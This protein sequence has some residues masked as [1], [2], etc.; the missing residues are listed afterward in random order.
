MTK[1]FRPEL[2]GIPPELSFTLT[3]LA[4]YSTGKY[5]AFM[6][7]TKST[8]G[9][10]VSKNLFFY[11]KP[12]TNT[13][14]NP[15]SQTIE[16][17]LRY[18]VQSSVSASQVVYDIPV[19]TTNRQNHATGIPATKFTY[20]NTAT[21]STKTA[22][23]ETP[24]YTFVCLAYDFMIG[25]TP[26]EIADYC[27]VYDV[28]FKG[29]EPRAIAGTGINFKAT[30]QRIAKDAFPTA[31]TDADKAKKVWDACVITTVYNSAPTSQIRSV[32]PRFSKEGNKLVNNT[33]INETF[34]K[35][36]NLT[37]MINIGGKT[38][39]STPSFTYRIKLLNG[40][41]YTEP[42]EAQLIQG[43]GLFGQCGG[44][45]DFYNDAIVQNADEWT[46]VETTEGSRIEGNTIYYNSS[47]SAYV[48]MEATLAPKS[49]PNA[50]VW[51]TEVCID[52]RDEEQRA[53]FIT[54]F[55][56]KP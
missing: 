27:G 31:K 4:S 1:E 44:Y 25:K 8:N 41:T 14:Y 26:Q 48:I 12:F 52:L 50:K 49:N 54:W 51:S 23:A 32:F 15:A 30:P 39:I 53:D 55:S 46:L 16:D 19:G 40:C 3:D 10:V 13:V 5:P 18:A 20:T 37:G 9:Q 28:T 33:F 21:G 36:I 22:R 17:E 29:G 38:T 34:W 7:A 11:L 42:T 43:F 45:Q 35:D 2:V 47:V 56:D 24:F 6:V